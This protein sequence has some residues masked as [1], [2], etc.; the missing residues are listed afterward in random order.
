VEQAQVVI[1][2]V[3]DEFLLQA[4][5]ADP[6][7]EAGFKVITASQA[8]EAIATLEREGENIRALIT[9]VNLGGP[10]TGWDVAQKARELNPQLPVIYATSRSSEDWAAHG[11]PNSVHITKPFVPVQVVTAVSQ[12]LNTTSAQGT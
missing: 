10:I 2:V 9:D 1:L 11:V 3:E 6:L 8:G 4:D 5:L 12:L 7:T